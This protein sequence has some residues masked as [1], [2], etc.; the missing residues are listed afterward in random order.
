M[1]RV[2]RTLLNVMRIEVLLAIG[3]IIWATSTAAWARSISGKDFLSF[4][5]SSG[6]IEKSYAI[7][8]V[9]ASFD[10][11]RIWGYGSYCIKF[12]NETT[13]NALQDIAIDYAAENPDYQEQPLHHLLARAWGTAFGVEKSE[14]QSCITE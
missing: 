8:Y 9:H 4:A 2:A 3:L 13:I 11:L 6:E 1:N 5:T 12:P 14:E 10:A 7:G